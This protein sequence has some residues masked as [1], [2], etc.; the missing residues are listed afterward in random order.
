[1]GR[2]TDDEL[3]ARYASCRAVPFVP[4]NEDYG[5]VTLEAWMHERPVVTTTD[6][7]GPAELVDHE[8]TGLVVEP[9]P[10]ALA[11]ALD[12]LLADDELARR[13]GQAGAARSA[14]IAW[15]TVVDELLAERPR[16]RRPGRPKVVGVSD[17]PVHEPRHG[18]QERARALLGA[19]A[20]RADVELI[21]FGEDRRALGRHDLAESCVEY[22]VER[23]ERHRS[24]EA[25]IQ[26]L[27]GEVPVADIGDSKLWSATPSFVRELDR[28]LDDAA[29]AVCVQPYLYAAIT[30]LRPDVPVVLDAQNHEH[31][32]KG[33]LLPSEPA[34]DWL[35]RQVE[36]AEAEAVRRATIVAATTDEDAR[37]LCAS[38]GVDRSRVIVVP[39]GVDSA[40]VPFVTGDERSRR[41]R[42]LLA[43][44]GDGQKYVAVFV[45]SGHAPNVEAGRVLVGLAPELPD[46][47]F[48]HIGGHCSHLEGRS[49]PTNTR[50]LGVVEDDELTRVLSGAA[51][52][53]NPMLTGSGSNLK[54]LRFLAAGVP[55]VTTEVGVRGVDDARA[56]ALVTSVDEMPAAVRSVLEAPAAAGERV[57]AGRRHAEETADWRVIG[58][59]FADV[60]AERLGW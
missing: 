52:A 15:P 22:V 43:R 58:R 28:S 40:A 17:Y 57:A 33:A 25:Q 46:L 37:A 30:S 16:A 18:G 2:L 41:H 20:D 44:Y 11:S 50:L 19:L 35:L 12:R 48:L 24:A 21:A 47:L 13:L 27:A 8:A 56:F 4:R 6:S 38:Y 60:V 32:M 55:V 49:I 9:D 1:V 31:S 23:S 5:Y 36:A 45:G 42:D 51:V 54:L 34:R 3:A 7:G 39:N 53:L 14:R 59:R 29:A 26:A 10:A